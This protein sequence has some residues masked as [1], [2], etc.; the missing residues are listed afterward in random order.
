MLTAGLSCNF[1]RYPQD[2]FSIQ[3]GEANIFGGLNTKS[4]DEIVESSSTEANIIKHKRYV[5]W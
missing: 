5:I 2:I 3:Q 1:S 4:E